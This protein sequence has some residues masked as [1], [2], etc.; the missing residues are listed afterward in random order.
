[1]GHTPPLLFPGRSYIDLL[2]LNV[3]HSF[4]LFVCLF[5]NKIKL[6][7]LHG[8]LLIRVHN[9]TT[10]L[11]SQKEWASRCW[12]LCPSAMTDQTNIW[13]FLAVII[14]E[15]YSCSI[16]EWLMKQVHRKQ[17]LNLKHGMLSFTA[18]TLLLSKCMGCHV[19]L[20]SSKCSIIKRNNKRIKGK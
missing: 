17:H 1:M 9:T 14:S 20:L 16:V 11:S 15:S 19:M 7:V 13:A 12:I 2:I 4:C 6:L 8:F 18:S 3:K 10:V 5:K